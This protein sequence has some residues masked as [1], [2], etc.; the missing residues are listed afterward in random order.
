MRD[1]SGCSRRACVTTVVTRSLFAGSDWS[2]LVARRTQV[3]PYEHPEDRARTVEPAVAA[4]TPERLLALQRSAGNHA[5]ARLLRRPGTGRSLQ[6]FLTL[7]GTK[8]DP[9]QDGGEIASI[10][11]DLGRMSASLADAFRTAVADAKPDGDVNDWVAERL[12]AGAGT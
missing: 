5:V 7:D 11:A 8:L 1:E 4:A 10:A 3:E 6:R 9:V 2:V 12:Q